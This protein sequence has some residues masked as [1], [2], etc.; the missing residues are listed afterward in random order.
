[1]DSYY[2][3]QLVRAQNANLP[4]PEQIARNLDTVH[5][6]RRILNEKKFKKEIQILFWG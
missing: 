4:S 5:S 3:I 2:Q 6:R 1:M